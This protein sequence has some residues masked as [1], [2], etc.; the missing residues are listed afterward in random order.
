MT[1]K[2]YNTMY[3]LIIKKEYLQ[4]KIN[5]YLQTV[6]DFQEEIDLENPPEIY[7]NVINE[8]LSI[9]CLNSLENNPIIP[10]LKTLVLQ[11]NHDSSNRKN[12][13]FLTA[14]NDHVDVRF[15]IGFVRSQRK[16]TTTS[17]VTNSFTNP[18]NDDLL[19]LIHRLFNFIGDEYVSEIKDSITLYYEYNEMDSIPNYNFVKYD[20]PNSEHIYPLD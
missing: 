1:E 5:H 17:I 19:L 13:V 8:Y 18:T 2:H 10:E 4:E 7:K 20:N 16:R 15:F 9:D 11:M 6:L 14:Q 12:I 3:G